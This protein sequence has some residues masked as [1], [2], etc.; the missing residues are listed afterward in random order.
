MGYR[1]LS[2]VPFEQRF[3]KYVAPMP[4]DR[5]CWEWMGSRG[6]HGYG[7]IGLPR[8]RKLVCAHRASWEMHFGPIPSDGPGPIGYCICHR[9]DNKTCVNPAHLFLGTHAD[10]MADNARKGRARGGH[11]RTIE[12]V[13]S[14][15]RL[16]ATG[17][18]QAE[19]CRS[20]GLSSCNVSLIVNRKIW[21]H[22]PFPV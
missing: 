8:S 14:V 15:L 10:N 12:E 3:W 21:R 7:V 9:C 16:H 1:H 6:S 19:I 13:Q 20:M 4:D 5:G 2:V 11:K 22:V 18:T 17:V